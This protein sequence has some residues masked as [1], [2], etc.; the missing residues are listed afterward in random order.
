MSVSRLVA[1]FTAWA[2]DAQSPVTISRAAYFRCFACIMVRCPG[3]LIG[4][5][6]SREKGVSQITGRCIAVFC[7]SEVEVVSS[8]QGHIGPHVLFDLNPGEALGRALAEIPAGIH[9]VVS[10]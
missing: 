6:D 7:S 3:S 1:G 8:I 5:I 4:D 10:Q 9:V 2:V